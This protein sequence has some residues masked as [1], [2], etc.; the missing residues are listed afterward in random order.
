[1]SDQ[2]WKLKKSRVAGRVPTVEQFDED[3]IVFNQTDGIIYVMK[4]VNGV[5]TVVQVTGWDSVTSEGYVPYTGATANVDLGVRSLTAT[6][7]TSTVVT[8]TSP[9]VVTSTTV[10]TN[11]NADLLDGQHGSYYS[12][13]SHDHAMLY[14]ALSHTHDYSPSGH[15]HIGLISGL[16]ANYIP[17]ATSAT[18]LGNSGIYKAATTT[19]YTFGM[20][21]AVFLVQ[22]GA[23][24]FKIHDAFNNLSVLCY[25]GSDSS[26]NIGV[27]LNTVGVNVAGPFSVIGNVSL[28]NGV[29]A[30][31][32]GQVWTCT[33]IL[34]AGYWADPT[35]GGD[36]NG[37]ASSTDNAITR[38]NG[39]GG[40]T[41]QNSVITIDDSGN[42]LPVTSNIPSLGS[43]S[44][45]W[46]NLFLG[47][48][49][50]LNF[51]NDLTLTHSTNLLTLAGG[52][53]QVSDHGTAATPQVVNV[54]YG[55]T[56]PP[57]TAA[58]GTLFIQYV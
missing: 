14:A 48:G 45:Y 58:E 4:V 21:S 37:P 54:C 29:T 6:Q 17:I 20:N 50:V 32:I 53:L 11:L 38:F 5:K 40:K 1:M 39:A 22:D 24:A 36:V 46:K 2:Y 8:G 23:T 44:N 27:T 7:L 31:V 19:D 43:T 13:T 42:L 18:V 30:P 57:A 3:T 41:L 51:N 33:S 9:L 49:S 34:G 56:T 28:R 52:N 26:L 15:T 10:V 35:G 25:N 47:S 16:T 55:T 12:P